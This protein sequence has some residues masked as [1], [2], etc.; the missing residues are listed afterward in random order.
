MKNPL[1][2]ARQTPET[3]AVIE[4]GRQWN[5]AGR[6]QFIEV[7]VSTCHGIDPEPFCQ[8]GDGPAGHIATTD[9]QN[10]FH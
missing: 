5:R 2:N 6:P 3:P 7:V 1:C 4:V 9:Y 10:A 8:P